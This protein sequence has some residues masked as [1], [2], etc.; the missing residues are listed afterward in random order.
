MAPP[1]S[2]VTEAPQRSHPSLHT[3]PS[4]E[5]QTGR[6]TRWTGLRPRMD[7]TC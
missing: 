2:D 1:L 3:E 4:V 5:D 6:L 7:R